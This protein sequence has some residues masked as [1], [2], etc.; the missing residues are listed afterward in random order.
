MELIFA[1]STDHYLEVLRVQVRDVTDLGNF[2]WIGRATHRC[3]RP[4]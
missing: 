3:R 2:L 1:L 4:S